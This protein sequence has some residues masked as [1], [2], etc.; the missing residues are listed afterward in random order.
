MI[1][2]TLNTGQQMYWKNH[3]F[4]KESPINRDDIF[5]C[6]RELRQSLMQVGVDLCTED[7]HPIEESSLVIQFDTPRHG[8]FRKRA[9][10]IAYLLILE[11]EAINP[12]NVD[13]RKHEMFDRVFTFLERMVDGEKYILFR[14]AWN[15]TPEFGT[16]G[17]RDRKLSCM[18]ASAHRSGHPL[19]LYSERRRAIRYF[20]IQHPGEF[21]L[22]GKGWPK[23]LRPLL[24]HRLET[25]LPAKMRNLIDSVFANN[26]TYR[27]P[28]PAKVPVLQK[29]RFSL[30]YEN[31]RDV[32]GY[33]GDKMW[34][35]MRAGCVPVYRGASNIRDFVPA[36]CFIDLRMYP[37]YE[38]VYR[39]MMSVSA[40]EFSAFQERMGEFLRS[41]E[42]RQFAPETFAET[43]T[44]WVKLDLS[45]GNS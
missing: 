2:A 30:C 33:V 41:K 31:M 26:P 22:Y 28:V 24:G 8:I 1:K 17:F 43:I 10:Q 38:S 6:Y 25:N 4:L 32:P 42:A 40:A 5:A 35:S 9:N 16:V 36:D 20:A 27:G 12:A 13:R 21:D 11:S 18:I 29:Y 44:K 34:D 19:E 3:I 37:N 7:I 39:Y 14:W 23:S 15:L 45:L